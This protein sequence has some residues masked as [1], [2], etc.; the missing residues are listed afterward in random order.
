MFI[1]L[2]KSFLL[3]ILCYLTANKQQTPSA[4]VLVCMSR[5][6][7]GNLVSGRAVTLLSI[8]YLNH[9][10]KAWKLRLIHPKFKTYDTSSRPE[11]HRTFHAELACR[12]YNSS[13]NNTTQLKLS[14]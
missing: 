3:H 14:S 5:A 12:A 9:I 2:K 6:G 10:T 13:F 8:N 4:V 1:T 11:C 7:I